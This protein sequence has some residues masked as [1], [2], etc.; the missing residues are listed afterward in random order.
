[1]KRLL[2]IF[3]FCALLGAIA[4]CQKD[5]RPAVD[6]AV[7][8]EGLEGEFAQVSFIVNAS[9]QEQQQTRA[10]ISDGKSAVNLQYA[11]YRAE[12]YVSSSGKKFSKGEYI[13]SLSQGDDPAAPFKNAVIEDKGEGKWLVTLTLVKNVK[14]DIVFW[15]YA[16][17]AP[18]T[19][20][21][22]GAMITVDDNYKGLANAE[23]RD[24]FYGIC[25]NYSIVSGQTDVEL[26]RPFAQ[27][28]F[29]ASDYIP[30]IT[31]LGLE[32]TSTF[33]TTFKVPTALNV[34]TGGVSGGAEVDFATA[35]IPYEAGNKL[36]LSTGTGADKVDYHWMGM[37]YIL[38]G[39]ERSVIDKVQ[40]VFSYNGVELVVDVI[41]VPFRRNFKTNILGNIFTDK[42]QFKVVIMPG[43]TNTYVRDLNE[44]EE[45]L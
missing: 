21:E 41:N 4:A 45:N 36:L 40:A 32:M 39:D 3:T 31:D 20:D 1:M 14:Y 13:P 25:R 23:N 38:A 9:E 42:A 44:Y 17:N 7:V 15:A 19:F 43:Y 18:Y 10:N 29:G 26:Q 22:P 33:N 11:V 16:N 37:N 2:K 30:Y 8:D 27:I 34:L 6:S 5:S 28:N 24:A 12:D 35:K